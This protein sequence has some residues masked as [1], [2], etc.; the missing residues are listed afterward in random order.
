MNIRSIAFIATLAS[1][2]SLFG[3]GGDGGIGGTGATP[4]T[5]TLNMSIT[6]APSCGYDAVNVTIDRIRVN[7]NASATD[8]DG[9]WSD[10]VLSPAKRIDLLTLTNGLLENLGQTT[11]PI[12][13]YTQLRLVLAANNATHPL[14]NSVV[15]T[16]GS[17][18]AL[19]TPSAQQSGIK[20]NVDIDVPADQVVSYALDFDACKSIVQRGAP[21]Q[22]NLKPV[23]RVIPV[24]AAPGLR[25]EGYVA[26]SIALTSTNVSAQLNGVVVKATPP[27]A[28]G[29]FTLSPVPAGT[30]DL[31]V[32][33]AGH[34]N[35]VMTG[36]PVA[37]TAPTQV[38]TSSIP[39][40]PPAASQRT[41]NG[42]V[43]PATATVR[44]LQGLTGGASFEAAWAPVDATTGSFTFN[45]PIGAPVKVG[46]LPAATSL[47]FVADAPVSSQFTVQAASG[48]ATKTQAIDVSNAV[49]A[50][51]FTFP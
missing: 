39:I 9:G 19:T 14:A 41:V 50:M 36:V 40:T 18:T 32:S 2:L 10:I 12:G 7:Q 44:V 37:A 47:M 21:G 8:T 26:P 43:A 38:N 22:Y 3:C 30:Y 13:N 42:T 11:L 29:K 16:G 48:G 15:P 4:A 24:T 46:Y 31:V 49:P 1:A 45:V 51:T 23:I 35:A 20:L 25:I 17:E 34:V 27:D 33:S 28:N 5:G 6:D